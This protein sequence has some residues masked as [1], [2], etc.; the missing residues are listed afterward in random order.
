MN[1]AHELNNVMSMQKVKSHVTTSGTSAPTHSWVPTTQR[2]GDT[3]LLP[4][5]RMIMSSHDDTTHCHQNQHEL[6]DGCKEPNGH[7]ITWQYM[8]VTNHSDVVMTKSSIFQRTIW[9]DFIKTNMNQVLVARTLSKQRATRVHYQ[10]HWS[11][12]RSSILTK[13]IDIHEVMEKGTM[14]SA[15]VVSTQHT[16]G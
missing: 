9:Y 1:T 11:M 15:L 8:S 6:G 13:K 10:T 3:C 5:C 4:Q 7:P 12:A 2:Q 14:L 16:H